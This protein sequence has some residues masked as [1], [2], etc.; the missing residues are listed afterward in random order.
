M[1]KLPLVL[2]IT[3]KLRRELSAALVVL[4]PVRSRPC[5]L[6]GAGALR[7]LPLTKLSATGNA[8]TMLSQHWRDLHDVPPL[9]AASAVIAG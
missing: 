4:D 2:M 3:R 8:A 6:H 9:S 7:S 5:S 1:G